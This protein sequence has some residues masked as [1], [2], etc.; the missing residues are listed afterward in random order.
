MRVIVTTSL[1][2]DGL[3]EIQQFAPVSPS[4]C[5][6]LAVN[7]GASHPTQLR[8]LGDARLPV[9]DATGTAEGA[10]LRLAF[11]HMLREE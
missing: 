8:K 6:V 1:G 7:I 2:G 10:V 5:H 9:G 4:G 3:Q 11:G